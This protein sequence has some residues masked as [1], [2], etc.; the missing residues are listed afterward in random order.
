MGLTN[1]LMIIV[2]LVIHDNYSFILKKCNETY[3]NYCLNGGKCYQT[4]NLLTNKN[5]TVLLCKCT[6]DFIGRRCAEY[7]IT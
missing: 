4:T 1:T 6:T 5:I 7:R 3:S 2:T